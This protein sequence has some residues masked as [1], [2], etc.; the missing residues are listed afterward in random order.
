MRQYH[1]VPCSVPVILAMHY[2]T[3]C[4]CRPLSGEGVK[5]TLPHLGQSP[6][7]TNNASSLASSP[8]ALSPFRRLDAR[9]GRCGSL[10]LRFS[11][12]CVGGLQAQGMRLMM[13]ERAGS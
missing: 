7:M 11:L 13:L 2:D 5:Y 12:F 10:G 9:V 3:G 8:A 1:A 6:L 4:Q